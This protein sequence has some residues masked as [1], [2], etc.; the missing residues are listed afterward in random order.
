MI[1]RKTGSPTE[2]IMMAQSE[3]SIYNFLLVY[4]Y[5]SR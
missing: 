4:S 5:L 3:R 1:S 2:I